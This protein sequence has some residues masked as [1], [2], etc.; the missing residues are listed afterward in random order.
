MGDAESG[1]TT[2][3]QSAPPSRPPSLSL[4]ARPFRALGRVVSDPAPDAKIAFLESRLLELAFAQAS[5]AATVESDRSQMEAKFSVRGAS[6][7]QLAEV[8]QVSAAKSTTLESA[9]VQLAS[10]S[11]ELNKSMDELKSSLDCV[12]KDVSKVLTTREGE[13]ASSKPRTL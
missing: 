12:R 10:P 3:V 8:F 1:A 13:P 7:Q 11:T 4:A 6:L 9:L 2:P 5:F